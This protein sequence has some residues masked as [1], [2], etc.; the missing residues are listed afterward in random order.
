MHVRPAWIIFAAVL[1]FPALSLAQE[2]SPAAPPAASASPFAPSDG[3][4]PIDPQL[5][6]D[7]EHLLVSMNSIQSSET[8]IRSAF[9]SM[10]P[11]LEESLPATA[12]RDKIIDAYE[13]K[14]AA[15]V[16]TSEFQD[17]LVA[18]YAKHFSDA[19][20][21]AIDVFYQTPAGQRLVQTLPD[22]MN[23]AQTLG[24][25]T[26]VDS[27]PR[28][29]DELC[30]EFPELEGEAKFCTGN[31]TPKQGRLISPSTAPASSQFKS[32]KNAEGN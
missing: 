18:I 3:D 15:L 29:L 11:Q 19:E 12:S 17:G 13:N 32:S 9:D 21:K 23:E 5:K 31:T 26:A 2:S 16:H 28:I 27:I 10:R 24:Q 6:S 7:I 4:Q 25:K 30:K 14:L 22:V 20:I 1:L 8:G